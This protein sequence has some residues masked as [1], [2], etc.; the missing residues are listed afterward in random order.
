[1]SLSIVALNRS[2][3][4]LILLST[5]LLQSTGSSTATCPAGDIQNPRAPKTL[6]TA[7]TAGDRSTSASIEQGT[8]EVLLMTKSGIVIA[9]DSRNSGPKPPVDNAQKIFQ[10]TNHSVCAIAGMVAWHWQLPLWN[11]VQGFSF[12]EAIKERRA[13]GGE[14]VFGIEDE[15]QSLAGSLMRNLFSGLIAP[16]WLGGLSRNGDGGPVATLL[17]AGYSTPPGDATNWR[18]EAYKLSIG[19]TTEIT[20]PGT[21]TLQM[22]GRSASKPFNGVYL[23]ADMPGY[24]KTY[25]VPYGATVPFA[26]FTNG[27]DQVV[28]AI[29]ASDTQTEDSQYWKLGPA[30]KEIS[31]QAFGEGLKASRRDPAIARYL[32]LSRQ[33]SLDSMNLD[34]ATSLAEALLRE[35]IAIAGQY[36]GIG[37]QID[38]AQITHDNGFRWVPGHNPE[39]KA[40]NSGAPLSL[41]GQTTVFSAF[42]SQGLARV[43]S[44]ETSCAPNGLLRKS[45]TSFLSIDGGSGATCSRAPA[46][47]FAD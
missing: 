31:R 32:E 41:K 33:S 5:L 14:S 13:R 16:N 37:G 26:L 17:V 6:A 21:S 42:P 36:L 30:T 40:R 34:E 23:S 10:L 22:R 8:L 45:L 43:C 15:A 4:A 19:V 7:A 27:N 24:V 46:N 2:R 11:E 39:N 35:S 12:P 3:R 29:V 9:A 20:V 38:V 25:F 1:M 47:R 18:I 44:N 28:Q